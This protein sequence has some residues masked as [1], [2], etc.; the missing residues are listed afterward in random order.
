MHVNTVVSMVAVGV[1][2]PFRDDL[3]EYIPDRL[4]ESKP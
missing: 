1:D 3:D 2:H 4:F